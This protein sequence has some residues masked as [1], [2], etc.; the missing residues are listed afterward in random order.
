MK[1]IL[2]TVLVSASFSTAL[3]Q[4]IFQ[5]ENGK[6]GLK[7]ADETELL[8]PEYDTIIKPSKNCFCNKNILSVEQGGKWGAI[9][10]TG[11]KLIPVKYEKIRLTEAD[12]IPAKRNGKWGFIDENGREVIPFTYDA[13][14]GFFQGHAGVRQNDKWGYIDKNNK[15]VISYQY[16]DISNFV[17]IGK[18]EKRTDSNAKYA[19]V[20]IGKKDFFIDVSGEKIKAKKIER[21][22]PIRGF[23]GANSYDH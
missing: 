6:Y 22:S 14:I 17:Y 4:N 2:F 10:S 3:A 23:L 21:Y 8:A 20:I 7:N 15:V 1:S 11:V 9:D 5:G 19:R 12:L 13:T 18:G 16:D